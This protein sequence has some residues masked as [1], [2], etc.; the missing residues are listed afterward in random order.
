MNQSLDNTTSEVS[1]YLQE[2]HQQWE[3]LFAAQPAIIQQFL[4][5]QAR[6]LGDALLQPVSQVK[7]TLPDR[8]LVDLREGVGH[9]GIVPPDQREQLAGGLLNRLTRTDIRSAVRQRL[10][11]LDAASPSVP[12]SFVMPPSLTWSTTCSPLVALSPTT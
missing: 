2:E 9:I 11:E 7:F 1:H 12:V 4:L 10:N 6:Q 8:V 5:A 3:A